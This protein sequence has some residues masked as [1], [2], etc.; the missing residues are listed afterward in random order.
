MQI[1]ILGFPQ[2]GKRTLYRLLTGQGVADNRKPTD[3]VAGSAKVRDARVD[4][5]ARICNP[6]RVTLAENTFVLCPDIASG[7][8]QRA[9]LDTARRC[10]LLCVVVRAFASDQVYHPAGS[11]DPERDRRDLEAE[12]ILA[13]LELV[14][15]RMLRIEKE[16]QGGQRSAGSAEERALRRCE[17]VLE[18][19]R[20]AAQA[21]LGEEERRAVRS[22]GLITLLPQLW[23]TNVS[24]EALASSA[25]AAAFRVSARIEEEIATLDDDAERREY[26]ASLGLET[27]G[28]DRLNRAAYAALGLISFYTIGP[29]EVRAWTIRRGSPAPKA[30]GKIHSDIERGFIRVEV[31]TYEDLVQAG[32]EKAAK[33]MGRV[34]SR[35]RD[36]VIADG[37]ICHFLFS[38]APRR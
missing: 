36:Y 16:C 2:A 30:G 33:A 25:E 23:I 20:P 38:T 4:V 1:G 9:W 17:A 26:L 37:D 13:D 34:M 7:P 27:G 22:L 31:I 35:G 11:V 18:E 3:L 12:L 19:G 21:E 29:D 5:L 6:R 32:S 15:N 10:D 28:L 14:L 8:G 24:E